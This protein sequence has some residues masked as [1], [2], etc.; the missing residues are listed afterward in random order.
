[1]HDIAVSVRNV[2]KIILPDFYVDFSKCCRNEYNIIIIQ[3]EENY[4][5]DY[6]Y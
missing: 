5:I 2:A 4:V 3:N 1:M 6:T